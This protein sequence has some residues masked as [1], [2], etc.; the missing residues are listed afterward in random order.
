[1]ESLFL[2]AFGEEEFCIACAIACS[3]AFFNKLLVA[4]LS[5]EKQILKDEWTVVQLIN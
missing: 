3:E 5:L 4:E 2:L 1:M